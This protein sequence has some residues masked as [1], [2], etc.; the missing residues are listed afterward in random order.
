MYASI[1][2]PNF[3]PNLPTK[4]GVFHTKHPARKG[5]TS[6]STSRPARVCHSHHTQSPKSREKIRDDTASLSSQTSVS[7]PAKVG[8]FRPPSCVAVC[9]GVHTGLTN[10]LHMYT[11]SH[12]PASTITYS[13]VVM[14]SDMRLFPALW[15]S[16]APF[17]KR[18]WPSFVTPILPDG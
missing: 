12:H 14:L 3:R 1:P 8:T 9:C 18:L 10:E 5:K 17:P 16:S 7:L 6:L 13:R 2:I 15:P 11:W 4:S